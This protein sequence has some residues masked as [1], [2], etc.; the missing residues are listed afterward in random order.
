MVG[1]SV[2]GLLGVDADLRRSA[3]AAQQLRMDQ[4]GSIHVD[5]KRGGDCHQNS[6][7]PLSS[8]T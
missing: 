5:Y 1:L 3:F 4:P 8:R 6:A 7:P 2:H